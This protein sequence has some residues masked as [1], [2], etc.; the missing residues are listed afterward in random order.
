MCYSN[1]KNTF[2]TPEEKE[3]AILHFKQNLGTFVMIFVPLGVL[4]LFGMR[5]P[6][7]TLI[8]IVWG[9][10]LIGRFFDLYRDENGAFSFFGKE[11]EDRMIKKELEQMDVEEKQKSSWKNRDLV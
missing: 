1:K 7:I 5:F 8:M 4:T 3:R 2:N 6:I 10:K 9:L 11:W